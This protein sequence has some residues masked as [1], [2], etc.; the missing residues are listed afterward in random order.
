MSDLTSSEAVLVERLLEII[1]AEG[2]VHQEKLDP[3]ASVENDLGLSLD[4]L[5]LIGNAI[6]RE[7][8]CDMPDNDMQA[9]KTVRQLV[10][11]I[12]VRINAKA[13]PAD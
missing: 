11:L 10:D 7:F 1:A 2:L 4:D 5:T 8:D 13:K 9:C 6:E 3:A 12:I